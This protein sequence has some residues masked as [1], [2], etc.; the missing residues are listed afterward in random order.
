M[1]AIER[2]KKIMKNGNRIRLVIAAILFFATV[3]F[4]LF[5]NEMIFPSTMVGFLLVLT[6]LRGEQSGIPHAEKAARF[7]ILAFSI[8]VITFNILATALMPRLS[9]SSDLT[10]YYSE[11]TTNSGAKTDQELE[12][13]FVEVTINDAHELC[14]ST[15]LL[16][17]LYGIFRLLS[18]R[19]YGVEPDNNK[20]KD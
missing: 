8:L 3:F 16:L 13:H 2:N 14:Y 6:S 5:D 12:D 19:R 11:Q 7:A 15:S 4:A 17:V 10:R 20:T 9:H 1:L 18:Q